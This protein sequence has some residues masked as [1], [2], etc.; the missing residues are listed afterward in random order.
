MLRPVLI[1]FI[2]FLFQNQ[3]LSGQSSSHGPCGAIWTYHPPHSECKSVYFLVSQSTLKNLRLRFFHCHKWRRWHLFF[4]YTICLL[5]PKLYSN[6]SSVH[7]PS[8][9]HNFVTPVAT[10]HSYNTRKA[11]KLNFYRP[12]ARTNMGRFSLKYSAP[13]FWETVTLKLKQLEGAKQLN[14]LYKANP[15]N[16]L[17]IKLDMF[18]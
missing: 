16:L 14:K 5:A 18:F 15:F 4:L 13:V 9:L 17:S 7:V 3:S 1:R 6:P 11:T 12:K 10:V 2:I 8:I